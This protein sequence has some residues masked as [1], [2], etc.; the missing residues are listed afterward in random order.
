MDPFPRVV[1]KS[2]V[3][4]RGNVPVVLMGDA[5]HTAHFSVGIRDQARARG[6][7]RARALHRRPSRRPAR[8]APPVRSGRG[9]EVL[10][11][12]NAARNST[13]GSRTSRAYANSS[14]RAVCVFAAHRAASAS[15][16]RTF[17]CATASISK[18]TKTSSRSGPVSRAR[19]RRCP[20]LR[21]SRR[22]P[23]AA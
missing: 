17:A 3:H 20:F 11:I 22:S 12:Q 16:T 6:R 19:R 9:V 5:A 15:V 23:C 21:C 13:N 2:W 10:R 7:D 18:A 14:A 1:C 4:W 8:R